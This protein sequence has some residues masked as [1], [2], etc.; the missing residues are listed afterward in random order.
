MILDDVLVLMLVHTILYSK[1]ANVYSITLLLYR[2]ACKHEYSTY[3][4]NALLTDRG[5]GKVNNNVKTPIAGLN[6][7]YFIVCYLFAD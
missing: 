6:I 2:R 4:F 3:K 7:N 5:V 1:Y